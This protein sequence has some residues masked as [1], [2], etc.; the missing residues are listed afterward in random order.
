MSLIGNSTTFLTLRCNSLVLIYF[1]VTV[2]MILSVPG[3]RLITRPSARRVTSFPRLLSDLLYVMPM[4]FVALL[5]CFGSIDFW[6]AQRRSTSR[7][8]FAY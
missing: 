7:Q 4:R 6:Q 1:I 5:V 3:K 8:K 2:L